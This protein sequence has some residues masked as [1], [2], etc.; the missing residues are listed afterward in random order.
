MIK[1]DQ[2]ILTRLTGNKSLVIFV[3]IV[4]IALLWSWLGT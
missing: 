2:S 1:K 3:A 4:I